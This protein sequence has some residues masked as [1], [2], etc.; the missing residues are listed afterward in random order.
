MGRDGGCSVG[1][2]AGGYCCR[3]SKDRL[4]AGIVGCR[5]QGK[6]S[7][8]DNGLN[9]LSSFFPVA[10]TFGGYRFLQYSTKRICLIPNWV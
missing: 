2:A 7:V 4:K 9:T 10:K 6:D 1:V 3:E 8:S 5:G